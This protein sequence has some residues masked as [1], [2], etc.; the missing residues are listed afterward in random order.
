MTR[1][2]AI[3]AARSELKV[4]T[5]TGA[6]PTPTPTVV[7]QTK[8]AS[9]ARVTSAAQSA[10]PSRVTRLPGNARASATCIHAHAPRA[11]R[12]RLA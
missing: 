6:S 11:W 12:D 8:A 3:V 2:V 4:T 5:A 10:A 7:P 9:R 1:L